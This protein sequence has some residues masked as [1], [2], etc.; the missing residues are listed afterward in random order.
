[1][2]RQPRLARLAPAFGAAALLALASAATVQLS[3]WRDGVTLF[4]HAVAV[5]PESGFA[6]NML[7]EALGRAGQT[8]AAATY[9]ARGVELDPS[10]KAYLHFVSGNYYYRTMQIDKALAEYRLTLELLPPSQVERRRSVLDAI[11][12]IER[13]RGGR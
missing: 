10:R 13:T 12:A 4:R 1:V 8:A 11:E 2:A 9:I 6:N 7:G 5:S 3:Y